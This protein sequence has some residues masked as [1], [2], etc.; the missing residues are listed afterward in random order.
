MQQLTSQLDSEAEGLARE[1]YVLDTNVLAVPETIYSLPPWGESKAEAAYVLRTVTQI[2]NFSEKAA[3]LQNRMRAAASARW[4]LS[5]DEN[6]RCASAFDAAAINCPLPQSH[7]QLHVAFASSHRTSHVCSVHHFK[8]PICSFTSSEIMRLTASHCIS[9]GEP[10]V[11]SKM[12]VMQ[13][14]LLAPDGTQIYLAQLRQAMSA[15]AAHLHKFVDI[16]RSQPP[17]IDALAWN[18]KMNLHKRIEKVLLDFEEETLQQQQ[19]QQQQQKQQQQQHEQQR[20]FYTYKEG[21]NWIKVTFS[22]HPPPQSSSRLNQGFGMTADDPSHADYIETFSWQLVLHMCQSLEQANTRMSFAPHFVADESARHMRHAQACS[23]VCLHSPASRKMATTVDAYMD[24]SGRGS[25]A[26]CVYGASGC[27]KTMFVAESATRLS[28]TLHAAYHANNKREKELQA[29]ADAAKEASSSLAKFKEKGQ[30]IAK[31]LE[32][33]RV[34]PFVYVSSIPAIIV[35]FI[36]LTSESSSIR[37]LISSICQQMHHILVATHGPTSRNIPPLPPLFDLEAMKAFFTNMLRSWSNGRLILFLDALDELDDSDAGKVLDW[38]PVDNLSPMVRAGDAAAD[39][40]SH[41]MLQ[42]HPASGAI[43][44]DNVHLS[45]TRRSCR[46]EQHHA[47][48]CQCAVRRRR[49]EKRRLSR[50]TQGPSFQSDDGRARC[51]RRRSSFAAYI[52][53]EWTC[54]NGAS[55]SRFVAS[56]ATFSPKSGP[57][58]RVNSRAAVCGLGV[59]RSDS[60]FHRVLRRR[61]LRK[62]FFRL[63]VGDVVVLPAIRT[64]GAAPWASSAAGC[65]RLHLPCQVWVERN[66]IIRA[67]F[68]VRRRAG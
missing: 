48:C 5:C 18:V 37:K 23:L 51:R 40:R 25:S 46:R 29:A 12:H 67:S 21:L 8:H 57:N 63:Q 52:R 31:T 56:G 62:R 10:C 39:K 47:R 20:S 41:L 68:A 15:S 17:E 22:S 45:D 61:R 30:Q 44:C 49:D 35:R 36:G 33:L 53:V 13:R 9:P 32:A 16:S 66:R 50:N 65:C 43:D 7:L 14:K 58:R 38:L 11:L 60:E 2:P 28:R 26:L 19:Q 55:N 27:G 54:C 4:D 59:L 24:S 1:L 6:G 34:S 64:H 3:A 42:P